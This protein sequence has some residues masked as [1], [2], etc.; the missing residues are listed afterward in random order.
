ATGAATVLDDQRLSELPPERFEHDTRD[1]VDR[2]A[3]RKR[4]DHAD[5]LG[6][7]ALRVTHARQRRHK[8]G[9]GD[10]FKIAAA[11]MFQRRR[12]LS[13]AA[14]RRQRTVW[15]SACLLSCVPAK[16]KRI[17]PHP[18]PERERA[19]PPITILIRSQC[20]S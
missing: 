5:R 15:L 17:S 11:R 14:N 10:D 2:A 16:S 8:G 12:P 6:G 3:G 7:P 4:D 19:H 9:T 13:S 18:A 20:S 1:N